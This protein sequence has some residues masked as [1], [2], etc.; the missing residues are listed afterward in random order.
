MPIQNMAWNWNWVFGGDSGGSA[1][2]QVNFGP[3]L[4]VA[5]A[6][7]SGANGDGLC[8][9]GI[10]QFRTRTQPDG[11]DQDH[12]FG[13]SS[14]FG[15]PPVAFDPIMTSVS[16]ELDVGGNGQQGV[17]TLMVWLWS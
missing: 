6:S 5:E 8:M 16:A 15:F 10:T 17:M 11:P 2:M 4:A 1:S 14:D 3:T 12:N 9:G 7:L 13:W